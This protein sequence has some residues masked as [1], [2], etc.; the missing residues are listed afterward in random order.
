M[1]V[2]VVSTIGRFIW[3]FGDSSV[4]VLQDMGFEVHICANFNEQLSHVDDDSLI[5]HQVDFCRSP[6]SGKNI[7]AYSQLKRILK[8]NSF[9]LI[10]C[11]TP[12][13]AWLSRLAAAQMGVSPVIYMPH[14][15]HFYQGAPFKDK[16]VYKQLESMMAKK[17]DAII[18]INIE[19]FKVASKFHLRKNGKVFYVP[20]V[21]IDLS[22]YE[23]VVPVNIRK[24]LALSDD[25][26]IITSVAELHQRKNHEQ[27]IRAISLLPEKDRIHYVVCGVGSREE[28]IRKLAEKEK[29]NLH[30]L[31]FSRD[32]VGIVRGSDL[33]AL[34][35]F[36]EGLSVAL[37]EAMAIGAPII[38]SRIRGNVDLIENN[39]NGLLFKCGDDRETASAIGRML[40]RQVDI[41]LMRRE[42]LRRIKEYD[43]DRIKRI[44]RGIYE[45]M[46]ISSG[47]TEI[48]ANP[49]VKPQTG[50]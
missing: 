11:Q 31:G 37:M 8:E 22:R 3:Q 2:L 23:N 34:A 1:R 18:C 35:S 19:D 28:M 15:F 33:F 17:T 38:A 41:E 50:L 21:G 10:H 12:V 36:R 32:A 27:M 29:I 13:A 39:V 48:A 20:G 40:S 4:K 42:N 26:F 44:M 9:D 24:E 5:K 46:I 43:M 45:E 14:G 30:L 7:K 6:F 16:L 49:K 25:D 47:K